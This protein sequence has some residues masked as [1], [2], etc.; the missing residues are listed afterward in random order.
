MQI[1]YT[2]D[3]KKPQRHTK[4]TNESLCETLCL[5]CDLCAIGFLGY[6]NPLRGGPKKPRGTQRI[7]M[8]LSVK[9][10]VFSVI[11]VQLDSLGYNYFSISICIPVAMFYR[12]AQ[13]KGI[14]GEWI[15]VRREER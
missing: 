12:T 5:L 6:A 11:F 13:E 2:E 3:T 10:C 9:L 1:H 15:E 8:N 7:Q 14:V 4:N